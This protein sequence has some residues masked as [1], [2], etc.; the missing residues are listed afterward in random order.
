MTVRR[1]GFRQKSNQ[2]VNACKQFDRPF[3]RIFR[4]PKDEKKVNERTVHLAT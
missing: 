2:R 1:D 4:Q 3:K